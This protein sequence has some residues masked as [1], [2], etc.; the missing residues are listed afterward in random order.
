[1]ITLTHESKLEDVVTALCEAG[2]RG[3][4]PDEEFRGEKVCR[5]LRLD[6]VEGPSRQIG[7]TFDDVTREVSA[8]VV[9]WTRHSWF[10]G[11]DMERPAVLIDVVDGGRDMG[12]EGFCSVV[13][14]MLVDA[15]VDDV[16]IAMELAVRGKV[17]A[18][19]GREEE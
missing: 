12:V 9:S 13:R 11:V 19:V 7:G 3:L 5:D 1:M 8:Y 2:Y 14:Y 10:R 17:P 6:V 16:R 15:D 18:L 4:D